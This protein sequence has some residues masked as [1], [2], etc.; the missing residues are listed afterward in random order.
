MSNK[1]IL[2]NA[3]W[4]MLEKIIYLFG[5]IFV[6]SFMAKYI[7]PENFG[8]LAFVT[9][10]F[11]IVQTICMFGLENIIFQKIS[12]NRKMG[13][14]VMFASYSIRNM[15]FFIISPML[16]LYLYFTSDVLTFIFSVS[17]FVATYFSLNDVRAIY[18]NAILNS[19]IN[20]ICN[21]L[22]LLLSL[23]IRYI[24]PYFELEYYWLSI[25]IILMTFVPYISRRIIYE[26]KYGKVNKCY[27]LEKHRG[28]LID[29]GK[30][31]V[32]YSLSVTLFTQTVQ[33]LLG[34]NSKHDL[35]I[36][37]VAYTFGNSFYFVLAAF[38]SSFMTKIYKE[39]NFEIS[40]VLVAK[41]NWIVV[42]ISALAFIFLYVFAE[43]LVFLLYGKEYAQSAELLHIVALSCCFSGMATVSEK[44]LFKFKAYNYLN[45][46]TM[47]L[48]VFNAV[49]SLVFIWNYAVY[50]AIISMLLLQ[51]ISATLYN[52]IVQFNVNNINVVLDSHIRMFKLR[53]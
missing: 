43:D 50:G 12:R 19:R 6:T 26:K 24:I 21:S 10:I 47:F 8:K 31:L 51:V 7:G 33:L 41:L 3:L 39:E 44:Y 52:Y 20:M 9:S 17:T 48:C 37:S 27:N 13:E 16:L 23:F 14:R 25:S 34:N 4:M 29:V 11:T 46:K 53:G 5:L 35:G 36:F 15:L 1:L 30:K 49:L 40:Q 45:R 18:F 22:G 38:I 42:T 32:I 28:Y 2:T